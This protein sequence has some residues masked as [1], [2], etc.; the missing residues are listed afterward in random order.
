MVI[1]YLTLRTFWNVTS[2]GTEH[3]VLLTFFL[4]C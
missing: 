3:F 4:N 1:I 2:E